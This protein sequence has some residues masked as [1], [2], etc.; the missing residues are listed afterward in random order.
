M[1]HGDERGLA[2]VQPHQVVEDVAEAAVVGSEDH[3]DARPVLP[4]EV[5]GG[6]GQR[7]GARR[8]REVGVPVGADDELPG[9][10]L[11]RVEAVHLA[12]DLHREIGMRGERGRPTPD[13]PA[14]AAVVK[15]RPCRS[16]SGSRGRCP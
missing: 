9:H 13:V 4:L 5:E 11:L 7:L 3:P 1:V 16:R 6:V 12:D 15:K 10:P 2:L 8:E 14:I